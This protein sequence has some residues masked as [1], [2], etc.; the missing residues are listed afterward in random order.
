MKQRWIWIGLLAAMCG[1]ARAAPFFFSTGNP[2]GV[3]A[4]ASRPPSSGILEIEA[5]DD[6]VLPLQ[7]T[8]HSATFTGL[9][10]SGAPVGS[11]TG[12][13]IEIYRVF[14]FD[15]VNPPSGAVPTRVNS[16]SDVAFALRDNANSSLN[17]TFSVSSTNFQAANSVLNGINPQPNQTTG[18]EGPV[19]GEEGNFSV[20]FPVPI[21]VPAGHYFFVPQVRLGSGNFYWLSAPKPIVS[22][23]TPLTVDLQAWIRNA[24]LAPNW[25]RI[26]TDIVGGG[27]QYNLAF[28]IT[29]EDDRIFGDGFGG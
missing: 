1:S 14:P 22:P 24:S 15:A 3:F 2:N 10:P 27:T 4:A 8:I 7:T 13:V 9:L 23:G 19:S 12:V 16:P 6:F 17:F 20:T 26:G 5:A 11:I 25:L 29:G 28:S 21:V 18:G